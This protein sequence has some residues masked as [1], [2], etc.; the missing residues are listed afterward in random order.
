MVALEDLPK[1]ESGHIKKDDAMRWLNNLDSPSPDELWNAVIPKPN[2]F[3][4]SIYPTEVSS[5]RVT[6]APE[7]IEAVAGMLKPL[8]DLES[9]NTRLEIN[10]QQ[11]EDRDTGELT[12][13]YAL[14]LNAAERA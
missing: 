7:F 14:Y 10:L 12:D 2:D 4:G 13:N 9:T 3:S 5:V 8:E 11:T 1:T 6:G